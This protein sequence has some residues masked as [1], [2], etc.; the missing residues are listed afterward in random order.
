[1][2]FPQLPDLSDY[3]DEFLYAAVP[4]LIFIGLYLGVGILFLPLDFWQTAHSKV[5]NIKCQKEK[6]QPWSDVKKILATTLPQIFTLY[7]LATYFSVPFLKTRLSRDPADLPTP[8]YF[9]LSL[10]FFALASETFFYYNHRLLHA[11][12]IYKYV[13]KKHHEFT[14]PL[15]LE[16]VY[17]HPIESLLNFGVVGL[18]PIL[19]GSHVSM[20]WLWTGVATSGILIHHCGY[21]VPGDCVPGFLDSMTH[22]HDYHHKYY[23]KAF[24]VLGI[25]DWVHGTGYDEYVTPYKTE[26]AKEKE[27]LEGKKEKLEGKKVA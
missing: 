25:L 3:S 6:Q 21:E 12:P 5:F 13:H 11:K 24:G 1:M 14:S 8:T 27:K 16:C 22:F 4:Y 2:Q 19:M 10:V 23:N 7:P 18:G 15:A 26:W 17:F 9:L 20:L